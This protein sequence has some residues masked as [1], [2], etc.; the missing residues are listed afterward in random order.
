MDEAKNYFAKSEAVLA[1]WLLWGRGPSE[2]PSKSGDAKFQALL[3]PCL[4]AS[5]FG[6]LAWARPA[7]SFQQ[8]PQSMI[9][10]PGR[11]KRVGPGQRPRLKSPAPGPGAR[12]PYQKFILPAA[13]LLEF[14][15]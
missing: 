2:A 11:A 5:C 3:R 8:F 14:P 1:K 10:K 4:G 7:G 12:L 9:R 13:F 15:S 6:G